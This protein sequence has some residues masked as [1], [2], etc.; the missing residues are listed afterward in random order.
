[1]MGLVAEPG[2]FTCRAEYCY[3]AEEG[4]GLKGDLEVEKKR[5]S[6]GGGGRS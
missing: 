2:I 4:G 3:K 6:R 5:Q 1:M